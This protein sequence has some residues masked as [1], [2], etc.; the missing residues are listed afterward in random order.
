MANGFANAKKNLYLQIAEDVVQAIPDL[1]ASVEYNA[2]GL[3]HAANSA[4]PKAEYCFRRAVMVAK[5][6]MDKVT[7]RQGLAQF[8]FTAG[9]SNFDQ[10]RAE[11]HEA[12]AIL[13]K[14]TD[15]YSAYALAYTHEAWA[16]CEL[17]IGAAVEGEA[18]LEQAQAFYEAL[19]MGM[20]LRTDG[21]AQLDQKA[22]WARQKRIH[23][24]VGS[25]TS[26]LA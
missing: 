15:A 26:R 7:A 14:P 5:T 2:L 23:A 22:E 13:G 18:L 6:Q 20:Y 9:P 24:T 11:F 25:G 21:L 1:V 8:L 3:E 12:V 10:G 19:P 17:S 4:F 16:L